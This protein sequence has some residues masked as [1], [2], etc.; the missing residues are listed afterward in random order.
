V[1]TGRDNAYSIF[2]LPDG[3]RPPRKGTTRALMIHQD[4]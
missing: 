2:P 1:N 3:P 4:G